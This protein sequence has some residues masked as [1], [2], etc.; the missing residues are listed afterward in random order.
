[1]AKRLQH[2]GGTTSQHSSFTGAVREVTVDTDKDTLV[3]HDGSTAGGF[4]LL[5]TS[6]AEP[7]TITVA[8][9]SD[10]L[11]LV[12]TDADANAGPILSMRRESGSPADNDLIGQ[13][14]FIG[15]DSVGANTQYAAIKG[16][17]KD[18][19]HN[20][21]D[22][23]L[24]FV[25]F[26][27][28]FLNNALTLGNTETVFN[29]NSIDIDFR[30]ESNNNANG[31]FFQGSSGYLGLGTSTPQQFLDISDNG[32][33]I[34]LS[35]TSISNLHHIIASEANDL[36]ISCDAASVDSNSHIRFKVDG[37][38]RTRITAEGH[39]LVGTTSANPG[40]GNTTTG[41]SVSNS[42]GQVGNIAISQN[43][44]YSAN[45]NRN[46]SDGTVVQISKQGTVKHV[47]TTTGI[48]IGNGNPQNKLDIS[49]LTWDDGILIKNTGNFNTGIIADA[50]RSSAS[51]GILNLQG[52]WNGT[53]VT[54]ILLQTGSDTTNKDDGE[55]VFR[56]AS[57]GTPTE[58]VKIHN[59][60]VMSAVN[61]IA[62]GVGNAN[63][64]SNVL[65]DY[66][67]GTWT[68]R[69]TFN[70]NTAPSNIAY[71][72]STQGV[73]TKVGRV[74]TLNFHIALSNK[75]TGTNTPIWLSGASLPFASSG[76]Y[77]ASMYTP[78]FINGSGQTLRGYLYGTWDSANGVRIALTNGNASIAFLDHAT[79]ANNFGLAGTAVYYV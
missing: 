9:N 66:E 13:L 22:G 44:N 20:T 63:T 34:R 58:R 76:I 55:I 69:I 51:G 64:A 7:L 71:A 4:P 15:K 74:V 73:Y 25:T 32:P 54:S 52:R 56:T 10:V 35:D 50:N 77:S 16:I 42:G 43:G 23:A 27:S 39:L 41:F 8:D 29:D 61:G 75:G 1:M 28:G 60:G 11:S 79:I 70:G 33:K 49:A 24:E 65:S 14:D 21:E 30:I 5:R 48:G 67:E 45:F 17:I 2:R 31:L 47:I 78:I 3:V 26:K 46:T 37:T 6:G 12:S 19:T 59:N 38:E 36:E 57:A 18:A 62:L 68:P 53:E 72:G 40:V